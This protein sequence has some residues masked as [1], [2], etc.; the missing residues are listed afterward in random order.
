[1]VQG[2]SGA[3]QLRTVIK[4]RLTLSSG[5]WLI[6]VKAASEDASGAPFSKASVDTPMAGK[7]SPKSE[8]MAGAVVLGTPEKRAY[9]LKRLAKK[10]RCD[11][12]T[13]S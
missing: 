12:R 5:T 1:M 13:R 2:S 11:D 9:R 6:S 4:A 3:L 8:P 7:R 10:T